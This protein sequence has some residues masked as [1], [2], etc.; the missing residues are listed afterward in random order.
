MKTTF[1]GSV[2]FL[3]AL[4]VGLWLTSPRSVADDARYFRVVSPTTTTITAFTPQ[5]YITWSNAISGSNYT[6]QTARGLADA[7]N[8]VD[9]IQISASNK[10]VTCQLYD[11]NP[12]AGMVLIPAGSF[13]MGNCMGTNEGGGDEFPLH[14]VYLSALFVDQCDVTE[15]QVRRCLSMGDEPWLQLRWWNLRQGGQPSGPNDDLV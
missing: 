1:S 8:W 13:M 12:P 14:A 5:G 3:F 15:G 10:V 11:S 2:R 9:Y 4:W 7:T 6:I